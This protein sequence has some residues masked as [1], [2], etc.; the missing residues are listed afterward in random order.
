M[1]SVG[2]VQERRRAHVGDHRSR[3]V[4]MNSNPGRR[5]SQPLIIIRAIEIRLEGRRAS[6]VR[7]LMKCHLGLTYH[8]SY[9]ISTRNLL[10][11]FVRFEKCH[12]HMSHVQ[13]RYDDFQP[14][15]LIGEQRKEGQTSV[16]YSPRLNR[17][18]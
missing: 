1:E 13:S 15:L 2:R 18:E 12:K 3:Q 9:H 11:R 8:V 7:M 17:H 10:F 16:N 6:M 4:W 14:N 5:Q